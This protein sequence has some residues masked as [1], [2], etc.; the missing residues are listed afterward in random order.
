MDIP[1]A[2]RFSFRIGS[3]GLGA[4]FAAI[5]GIALF[6]AIADIGFAR[7]WDEVT[8]VG[9]GLVGIIAVHVGQLA[10]CAFAWSVLFASVEPSRR[11]GLLELFTLRWIRE[12]IDHLLPVAQVGGEIAAARL[13]AA[14]RMSLPAAGASIIADLTIET[15]TQ[16]L[17][18]LVGL[19]LIFALADPGDVGRWAGLGFG[20]AVLVGAIAVFAQR[21]GGVRLFEKLLLTIADRMGWNKLEGI[22]GLDQALARF[23]QLRRKLLLAGLYHMA[24]WTLGAGEVLIGAWALGYP[25]SLGQAL[26][27][28]SLAQA[29]RS[30]AFFV[31][32][33]LG[34][35]E[36]GF[37]VLAAL[38]GIPSD[39]ALSLSLTK[40]I[41]E[42]AIGLPGLAAW[43]LK[44]LHRRRAKRALKNGRTM[45]MDRKAV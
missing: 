23:Y 40:R 10:L 27:I 1:R 33:A 6:L 35:Q 19:G 18:T 24:A 15:L 30:V 41:R 5:F 32:G 21:W 20:M 26:V 2:S 17:F 4:V 3:L 9:L 8:S 34:V 43:Q 36:G 14:E 39:V 22:A 28:E 7:I 45:E 16:A 12:S 37:V 13:M 44:E 11:P 31:P 38:F 29:I 42:L 25:V